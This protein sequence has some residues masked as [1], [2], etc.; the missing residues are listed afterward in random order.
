MAHK[1]KIKL[2]N[3][4]FEA[5]GAPETVQAQYDQFL[6]AL[7]RG[8]SKADSLPADKD[9]PKNT[10]VEIDAALLE[11]LFRV[12]QDGIVTLLKLPKGDNGAADAYLLIL[13]GYRRLKQEEDVAATHLRQ[14]AVH[15]GFGDHW[16]AP[17]L[18]TH[19]QYVTSGGV[20]KGKTYG[21]NNRGLAKAEEIAAQLF[22]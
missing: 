7:E 17:E 20:K 11:R 14:A 21:L 12:R 4:E 3:A 13:Y 16:P 18:A 1:I 2:G 8:G 5:E 10:S 15:S 22:A 19:E 9:K 6:A